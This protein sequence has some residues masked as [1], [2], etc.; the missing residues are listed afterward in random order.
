M[1]RLITQSVLVVVCFG[2]FSS[3][4]WAW[5]A[6][7]HETIALIAYQHLTPV[8]RQQVDLAVSNMHQEYP[9]L[10]SYAQ[11]AYWPDMIRSQKIETFTRWHY[12]DTPFSTDGTALKNSIDT[13][14]AVWALDQIQVIVG[15]KNANPIE[16]ARFIAFLTHIVGDEHQPLHTVS[17]F[18]VNHPYGDRGGN[19]YAIIF[20][21]EKINLHKFWDEGAGIFMGD[22]S[23]QRAAMIASQ[24]EGQYPENFF[25]TQ[26]VR[27]APDDWANEGVVFA[28]TYVYNTPENQTLSTEYINQNKQR[29][30]QQAALA[31][32]RLANELN[33]L[34]G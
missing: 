27:F 6:L 13:D 29:A 24:I 32:Y 8:A 21:G 4:L 11:L 33:Q 15:N 22:F 20:N 7:G 25:N 18:A 10:N 17:R 28:K 30:M 14:N 19:D 16:R 2:L 34:L 1:R 26:S 5:N 31:G 3:K 23:P 9:N 12:I